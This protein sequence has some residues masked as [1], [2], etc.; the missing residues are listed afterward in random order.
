[1]SSTE[2]LTLTAMLTVIA[3]MFSYVEAIIPITLGIPGFKLGFANIMVIIALYALD[4]RFAFGINLFR[5]VLS[6][7]LFGSPFSMMYSLAGGMLSLAVMVVLKKTMPLSW[8]RIILHSRQWANGSIALIPIM[9]ISI[10][11]RTVALYV[12]MNSLA[13]HQARWEI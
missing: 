1:M 10:L 6:A 4:T 2:R 13:A 5:I 12:S 3:L 11:L 9:E 7:L 8:G